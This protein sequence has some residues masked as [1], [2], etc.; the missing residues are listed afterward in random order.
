MRTE[1]MTM[2]QF[3]NHTYVEPDK[4]FDKVIRHLDKHKVTYQVIGFTLIIMAT[5]STVFAASTGIDIG[6]K[7]IYKQLVGIGKWVIIFK[8]AWD[9]IMNT[10]RGDF[11]SAKKSF[12]QYIL[13]Y[14]VLLALPWSMDRI[15]EVFQG[16]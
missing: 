9:T 15:D 2:D 8:G 7:K 10:V 6:G 12:M 13:I 3:L 4:L 11:D 1:V 16:I 14:V 5:S